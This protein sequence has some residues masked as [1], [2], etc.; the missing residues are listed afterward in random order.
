MTLIRLPHLLKRV[1]LS[2]S[3][4]YEM[5]SLGEFPKPIKLGKRAVAWRSD[6]IDL[7]IETRSG[8]DEL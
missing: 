4:I 1:P 6:D 5:M 7:W 2:R 3:R 8:R